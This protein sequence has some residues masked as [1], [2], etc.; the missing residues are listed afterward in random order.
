MKEYR[1]MHLKRGLAISLASIIMTG[2]TAVIAAPLLPVDN[3][4]HGIMSL[5]F[6][7]GRIRHRNFLAFLFP[8]ND[9][10]TPLA[11]DD[12]SFYIR[13][14]LRDANCYSFEAKNHPGFYLRHQNFRLHLVQFQFS[15]IFFADATFCATEGLA[16]T[17]ISLKASNQNLPEYYIRHRG[18][19]IWLEQYADTPLF[20]ADA[21]F[22]I[23]PGY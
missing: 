21:T 23:V 1:P 3:Q 2:A 17:G 12:S 8:I 22:T 4:T 14:G 13:E 19:E 16:G 15:D 5:N 9:S 7:E 10:S 6:P 11:K 20:K 18:F